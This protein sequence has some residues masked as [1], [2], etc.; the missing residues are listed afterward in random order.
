VTSQFLY[1]F[2]DEAGLSDVEFAVLAAADVRSYEDVDSL[3][4]WFPSIHTL[5][6]DLPRLSS[7]ANKRI[8]GAYLAT[9]ATI[10]ARNSS[11]GMG[12]NPPP[13]G[14]PR[15]P[16]GAPIPLG[17]PSSGPTPAFAAIDLRKQQW[18]IRNQGQRGTCVAFAATACVEYLQ[19]AARAPSDR[20]EQF[21]YWA[22]KT[23]T[24]DLWPNLDGSSLVF[25]DEALRGSGICG[26]PL[27]PYNPVPG[28]TVHQ[29]DVGNPS[30][31][32]RG[33]AASNRYSSTVQ[34][35]NAPSGAAALL[36]SRLLQG[37]P[38][39]I[40]L[41][42]FRDL[43]ITDGTTNWT[44]GSS[45]TYG[46]V[47]NPVPTSVCIEEGG[48]AVCVVGFQPDANEPCGGYFIFRNSWDT[49][50]GALSPS[51]GNTNAPEPGYGE[52]SATYIDKYLW[53]LLQV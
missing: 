7:A 14:P 15:P 27:W 10:P 42:V 34:P 44:D 41:P 1:M 6:V 48:H 17:S 28:G 21:L 32:A 49:A 13:G 2:R 46:R 38:V 33:D 30:Q 19:G 24:N 4:R 45:W 23:A 9:A 22:I 16:T 50:W 11:I 8:S 35:Q 43:L 31:Q 5:G 20:S 53:E 29:G 51:P 26:S 36:H 47:L 3:T 52:V 40:T 25:A 18:P 37:R 12:A 39:A